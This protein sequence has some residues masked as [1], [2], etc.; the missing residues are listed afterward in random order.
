MVTGLSLL[1]S[2]PELFVATKVESNILQETGITPEVGKLITSFNSSPYL[3]QGGK[4]LKDT[5]V[6]SSSAHTA[7]KK[8]LLKN[9]Y[10]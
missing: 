10:L 5:I 7:K 1:Q 2:D 3:L 6:P 4:E 8:A 9:I